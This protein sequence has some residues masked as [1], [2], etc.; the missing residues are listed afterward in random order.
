LVNG[1]PPTLTK[2]YFLASGVTAVDLPSGTI[3][4]G[5][6][7]VPIIP[8][9]EIMLVSETQARCFGIDIDSKSRCFGGWGTIILDDATVIP[10]R[11]EHALMTCPI[12]LPTPDELNTIPVHWLTANAPWD[13]TT[14]SDNLNPSIMVPLG[15]SNSLGALDLLDLDLDLKPSLLQLSQPLKDLGEE[16][17]EI[18]QAL[19]Y[20]NLSTILVK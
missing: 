12:R 10:L 16:E 7:E 4:I 14:I 20:L 2:S 19:R 3:L 8:D 5:Q 1:C 11:L 17:D 18:S 15:Y 13:P 6:H 9:S